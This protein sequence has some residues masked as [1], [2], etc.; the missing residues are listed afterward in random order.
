MET[1]DSVSWPWKAAET[2]VPYNFGLCLGRLKST[3]KRI[4][5]DP[6]LWEQYHGTFK[7]QELKIIERVPKDQAVST[8][9]L[10]LGNG[11]KCVRPV[12]LS[13]LELTD[14]DESTPN[15]VERREVDPEDPHLEREDP[16]E[17]SDLKC[18]NARMRR[19]KKYTV[20]ITDRTKKNDCTLKNG[21]SGIVRFSLLMS[22]IM[23]FVLNFG[24]TITPAIEG[25]WRL[26]G[27]VLTAHIPLPAVCICSKKIELP[28]EKVKVTMNREQLVRL[29]APYCSQTQG[30]VSTIP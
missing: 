20:P 27:S 4:K 30:T 19:A 3:L 1:D 21:Q 14:E 16:E 5:E 23:T 26:S 12:R 22:L 13:N 17:G 7:Q 8:V 10:K 24:A 18:Y 2:R 25:Q 9:R 11:R 29:K 15:E 6:A 28:V